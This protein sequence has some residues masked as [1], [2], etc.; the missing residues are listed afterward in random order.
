MHFDM[1]QI[2]CN[3]R[4]LRY[5]NVVDRLTAFYLPLLADLYA[6][7]YT[8]IDRFGWGHVF[9]AEIE[10]PGHCEGLGS[11]TGQRYTR[12]EG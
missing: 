9:V 2:G 10:E 3:T 4:T 11:S 7:P 1:Q 8:S 5:P 6:V 12:K